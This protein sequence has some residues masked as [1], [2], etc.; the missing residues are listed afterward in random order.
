MKQRIR[1]KTDP[2]EREIELALRPGVFIG[3]SEGF[4]FVSK[5]EEVAAKIRELGATS[6]GALLGSTRRSLRAAMQRQ[7]NSMIRTA[8]SGNSRMNSSAS[9]SKLV[10]P[11]APNRTKPLLRFWRG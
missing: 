2:T 1:S 9:G 10:R 11:P 5:L 7:M 6:P 3:Y 8:A 4:S